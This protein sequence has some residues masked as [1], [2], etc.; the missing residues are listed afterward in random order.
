MVTE[1]GRLLKKRREELGF[2]LREVQDK[3]GLSNAYLSQIENGKVSQPT[4]STLRKLSDHYEVPYNRLLELAGHPIEAGQVKLVQFRTST[5][6]EELSESE[7]R[8]LLD[9]LRYLRSRSK[10]R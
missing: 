6:T 5:G 3:A 4:P 1:L 10:D 7:E 2:T 8:E 9:Y